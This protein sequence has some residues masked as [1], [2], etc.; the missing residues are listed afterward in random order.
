MTRRELADKYGIS[1]ERVQAESL[2]F[3]Q[4]EGYL[5]DGHECQTFGEWLEC[6]FSGRPLTRRRALC[7]ECGT[8][9]VVTRNGLFPHDSS[10]V[11]YRAGRGDPDARCDGSNISV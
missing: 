3:L 10:G 2:A 6:V 5:G 8:E 9:H 11:D 4:S 1:V 7:P